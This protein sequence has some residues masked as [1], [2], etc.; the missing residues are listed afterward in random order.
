MNLFKSK[1]DI[2]KN[3]K[4]NISLLKEYRA[5]IKDLLKKK[6]AVLISHYYVDSEIQKIA[7]ETG[8]IVSDSLEMAKFGISHPAKT[9]VIAG[10]HFMGETAKILNPKKNVIMPT[11]KATCSL[12]I[13]CP[14]EKF[15]K[16]RNQH[17]DRIAVVY[18]NTSAMIKAHS[19]WVVTSSCA[20]DIIR[21][22]DRKKKK[23]LWAPDKFLGRWIQKQTNA[24]IVLWNGSCIVHEEFKSQGIKKL[25]YQYPN[26]A[27]LVHPESPEDVIAIADV[28]GST[29][30]LL[31]A[32][33]SLSNNV[34]IVATD[35]GIFYKMQSLSPKKVFI[36][37]PTGGH[38][39]TCKSCAHCPWM[40]MNNLKN[41]AET[42]EYGY[43]SI[44]IENS[45][46]KKALISL[47]RM[48]QFSKNL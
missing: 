31:K 43:N 37:A 27:I 41:L 3:M 13:G 22:L 45:I 44:H 48:I 36:E 5:K 20:L 29:S 17:P 26:S 19:D 47:N 21:Y 16:F 38:G 33:Q 18:A 34:F 32:T 12:D 14:L 23:I 35:K 42:L 4:M 39:A 28:V 46:Q 8:G 15:I 6:N 24:D 1:I 25:K 9:L 7:E 2:K 30:V 40:G 11:L 10:V